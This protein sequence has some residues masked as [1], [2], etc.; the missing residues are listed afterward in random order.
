[1]PNLGLRI[2]I[3]RVEA[4][5]EIPRLDLALAVAITAIAAL[6]QGT[7]GL[8]FAIV[9]VP[10]LSLVD[11]RLAP[12]PQLLLSLPLTVGMAIRERHAIEWRG[13]IWVLVGRL[14]GVVAGLWL[15]EVASL[16]MLDA[17]IGIIV[18]A[19]V[20]ILSMR[21]ARRERTRA[22]ELAAGFASG[23]SGV[24]SSIGGPPL[25]LLYRDDEGATI[26]ANLAALFAIG[27]V[28]SIGGRWLTGRIAPVEVGVAAMLLPALALGLGLSRLAIRRLDGARLRRSVLVACALAAVALLGRAALR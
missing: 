2:E 10:L 24:I 15:L 5:L 1:L 18:L 23:A 19:G 7:I 12:V 9:A 17:I 21:P 26:R 22:S 13:M 8:G 14:P 4:V 25:A 16:R 3:G 11:P 20:A 6:I 28:I 27:L